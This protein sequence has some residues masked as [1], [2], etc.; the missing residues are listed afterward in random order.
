MPTGKFIPIGF[1]RLG[2]S[3]MPKK[4]NESGEPKMIKKE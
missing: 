3:E 1:L 4:Y 2:W